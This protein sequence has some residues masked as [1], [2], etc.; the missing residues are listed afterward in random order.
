V[1]GRH[2]ERLR[3]DRRR[4]TPG[5]ACH[6]RARP[7]AG[8]PSLHRRARP[9]NIARSSSSHQAH[10]STT[11]IGTERPTSRWRLAA[12]SL[13]AAGHPTAASGVEQRSRPGLG[14]GQDGWVRRSR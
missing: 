3:R 14:A 6:Q 4:R 12:E 10:A 9:P 13:L 5:P 7:C 8:L 2:D 11:R 1:D